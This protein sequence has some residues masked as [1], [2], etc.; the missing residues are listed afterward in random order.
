MQHLL[1]GAR[2]NVGAV[3]DYVH[4]HVVELGASTPGRS[5]GPRPPKLS[6]SEANYPCT[7][8]KLIAWCLTWG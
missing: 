4:E 2:W 8:S 5:P 1:A 7:A 3:G 6:P